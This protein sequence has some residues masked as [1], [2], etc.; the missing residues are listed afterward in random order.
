MAAAVLELM[1]RYRRIIT[2]EDPRYLY[3]GH[4]K[5]IPAQIRNP[6]GQWVKTASILDAYITIP[7]QLLT[8]EEIIGAICAAVSEAN[9]PPLLR[10]PPPGK[11]PMP[12]CSPVVN[13][14][15]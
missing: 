13:C 7:E 2:Y 12:V 8:E 14:R 5:V 1:K 4:L 11:G 9:A 6:A 3:A 10:R 15:R